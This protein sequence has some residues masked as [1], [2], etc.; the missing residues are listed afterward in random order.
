[1]KVWGDRVM[2][3]SWVLL[4]SP[5]RAG[6]SKA[7]ICIGSDEADVWK[8]RPKDSITTHEDEELPAA[9]NTKGLG[10]QR[11]SQPPHQEE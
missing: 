11:A 7:A 6:I 4:E 2:L 9:S 1:M 8:C 10:L 3:A 5:V